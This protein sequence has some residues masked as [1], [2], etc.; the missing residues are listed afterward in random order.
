[1]GGRLRLKLNVGGGGVGGIGRTNGMFN[2]G[3]TG[4][5]RN[6]GGGMGDGP[7][8]GGG[9]GGIIVRGPGGT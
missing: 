3:G 8:S 9:G 1:V 5:L 2:E 4:G 7:P 6:G